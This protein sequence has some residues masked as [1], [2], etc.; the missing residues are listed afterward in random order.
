YTLPYGGSLKIDPK[1]DGLVQSLIIAAP[2]SMKFAPTDKSLFETKN[3]PQFQGVNFFVA[4]NVTPQQQ[5]R[6][7]IS[8]AGHMPG[9]QQASA[10]GPGGAPDNRPGGGMAPPNEMPDPL[11]SGQWLFLGVMSLFLTAGAVFVFTSNQKAAVAT[12]KNGKS[13]DRASVLMEA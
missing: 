8:G 12:G 13:K 7:E 1:S 9:E 6:F 4:K 5:S 11:H 3:N 10:G 2:G